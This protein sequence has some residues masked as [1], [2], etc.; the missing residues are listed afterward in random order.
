MIS[1]SSFAERIIFFNF[2]SKTKLQ[3]L[4]IVQVQM[5]KIETNNERSN[6]A[7]M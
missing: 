3:R 7:E 2:I 6:Q 1:K 5:N 4:N